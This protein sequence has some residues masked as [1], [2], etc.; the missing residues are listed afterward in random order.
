MAKITKHIKCIH[1]SLSLFF[2][3]N[4]L[5]VVAVSGKKKSDSPRLSYLQMLNVLRVFNGQRILK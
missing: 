2:V 1:C 3:Q 5:S 4:V